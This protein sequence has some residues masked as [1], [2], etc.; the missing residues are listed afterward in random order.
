MNHKDLDLQWENKK[1]KNQPN[2][3][4]PRFQKQTNEGIKLLALYFMVWFCLHLTYVEAAKVENKRRE[5]FWIGTY[6]FP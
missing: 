4:N 1:Q 2:K 5:Q 3:N 6:F